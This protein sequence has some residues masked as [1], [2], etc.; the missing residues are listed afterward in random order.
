[1]FNVD[2][3]FFNHEKPLRIHEQINTEDLLVMIQFGHMPLEKLS[4]RTLIYLKSY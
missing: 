4:R 1:M 3:V 2:Y